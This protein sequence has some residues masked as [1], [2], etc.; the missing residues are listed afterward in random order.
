MDLDDP[1]KPEFASWRSYQEFAQRVR[2]TRRYVWQ[3]DVEAFLSTVL[4]TLKDRDVTI[5]QGAILYRAQRGIE[6]ATVVD[7]DGNEV[8][9][10]LHGFGAERM[11]PRANRAREG[12]ANPAGIRCF[13][14]AL[15]SKPPSPKSGHGLDRRFRSH[16]AK[17]CKT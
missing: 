9:E 15:P 5:S 16:N 3:N 12:R 17:S 10:E 7:D 4:A 1:K 6:Y 2:Y 13:T 8:G 11:K 14:S